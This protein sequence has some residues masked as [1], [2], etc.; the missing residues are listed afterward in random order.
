MLLGD[1]SVTGD[2]TLGELAD[3]YGLSIAVEETAMTLAEFIASRTVRTPKAGDIVPLGAIALVV[4]RVSDGRVTT[5]G[6]RLAEELEPE[7]PPATRVERFKRAMR[8][9]WSRID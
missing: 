9:L 3:I 5:I 1:F 6:L 8:R 7:T 2:H 4:Q